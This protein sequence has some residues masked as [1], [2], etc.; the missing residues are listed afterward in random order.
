MKNIK[1]VLT[2]L[3]ISFLASCTDA[4]QAKIGGLGDEFKIEVLNCDGSVTH[5]WISSGKVRSEANS[6]GY[7]FMDK[8]TNKLIE[9]SGNIIITKLTNY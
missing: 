5:Y 1:L 9:V 2:I 8:N 3:L 6:D 7:Y 4:T